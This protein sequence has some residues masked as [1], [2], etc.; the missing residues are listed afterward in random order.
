ME[1]RPTPFSPL[2]P[3]GQV[4]IPIVGIGASTGGLEAFTHLFARLPISTGMAYVVIQH[5]DPTHA[6]L[7]PSL[8]ARIT[9]M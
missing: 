8:L 1:T 9:P 7:L 6:S 2:P 4:I 3:S 5:L